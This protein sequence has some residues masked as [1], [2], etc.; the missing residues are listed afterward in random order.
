[1]SLLTKVVE[2]RFCAFVRSPTKVL[3]RTILKDRAE[4]IM[5]SA[6]SV[7]GADPLGYF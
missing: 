2:L 3:V 1:M 6:Q 7:T 4:F 5:A